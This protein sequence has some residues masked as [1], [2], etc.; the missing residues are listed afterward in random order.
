MIDETPRGLSADNI[1]SLLHYLTIEMDE[2]MA[3]ARQGTAFGQVRPADAKIAIIASRKKRTLS[4][5]ARL[6]G[7]S[8]QAIHLAV[9]RLIKMQILALEPVPQDKRE[10]FVVI[11]PHGHDAIA[12]A[13]KQIR[14]MEVELAEVIGAEGV[15]TLRATVQVLLHH[16][17]ARRG[18]GHAITP[19]G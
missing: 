19:L 18:S 1:R 14:N 6:M 8:R 10:K 13:E 4:E 7:V 9:Q 2:Q 5:L 3:S 16:L 17:S 15:E 11:T 12:L